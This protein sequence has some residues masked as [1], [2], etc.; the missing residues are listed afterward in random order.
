MLLICLIGL[1]SFLPSLVSQ[2]DLKSLLVKVAFI[3]M[4][5]Q[6]RLAVIAYLQHSLATGRFIHINSLLHMKR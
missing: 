3:R 5:F 6:T 2:T 4:S 1:F